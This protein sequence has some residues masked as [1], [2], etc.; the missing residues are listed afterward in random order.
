MNKKYSVPKPIIQSVIVDWEGFKIEIHGLYEEGDKG[1]CTFYGD[2]CPS[3][4]SSFDI[5][6]IDLIEGEWWDFVLQTNWTKEDI[7]EIF[8]NLAIDKIEEQ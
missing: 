1:D 6:S 3:S 2:G 7:G 5:T 8:Q 4:P